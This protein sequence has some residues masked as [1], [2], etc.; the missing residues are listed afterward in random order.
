[1]VLLGEPPEGV[2]E[3]TGKGSTDA[4]AV[5]VRGVKPKR[6]LFDNTGAVDDYI[7]PTRTRKL[8]V[9]SVHD[10]SIRPTSQRVRTPRQPSP[11]KKIGQMYVTQIGKRKAYSR[12]P[13]GR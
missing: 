7:S 8:D 10:R 4:S 6:I 13:L 5:V 1:M 9:K 3:I 2:K 12:R 11:S